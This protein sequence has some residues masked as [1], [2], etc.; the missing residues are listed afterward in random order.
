VLDVGDA[1]TAKAGADVMQ[2]KL[3]DIRIAVI[4]AL[5]EEYGIFRQY[6]P[7]KLVQKFT[8]G[9][10]SIDILQPDD[11]KPK[12]GLASI[13]RMGNVGAAVAATRLLEIFDLDLVVNI[14][15][16][17]GVDKNKQALGDIIVARQI[18]Y[19]EAGK[20]KPSKLE[21]APEYSDLHSSFV[22][23]LETSDLKNWPLG[24]SIQGAARQVFF[25][26][27]ASGEKVIADAQFVQS[28]LSQDRTIVGIEMESHGIAAA[29]RGRKEKFLLIRGIS[30]LADAKKN[31]KARLSAMEGAT[32]LFHEALR[33]EVLKPTSSGVVAAPSEAEPKRTVRISAQK[34]EGGVANTYVEIT[35]TQVISKFLRR[36]SIVEKMLA[37][38]PNKDELKKFCT[39]LDIDFGD[40]PGETKEQKAAGILDYLVTRYSFTL[41]DLEALLDQ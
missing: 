16:A 37:K 33:R 12:I 17:G 24:A 30:D 13:N 21:V 40:I 11:A 1:E 5:A 18:R 22:R 14:G 34:I 19:Y 10:L 15:L 32:R 8:V 4:V 6:F 9:D 25:G 3:K 23:S 31:D 38:Y 41:E 35:S 36:K 26:T 39:Y 29:L 2:E 27:V 28:L 20:V 7:S